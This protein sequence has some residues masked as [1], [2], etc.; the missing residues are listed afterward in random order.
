MIG[1]RFGMFIIIKDSGKRSN[2]RGMIWRCRC[3][4]GEIKD[5]SYKLLKNELKPR[6]CGCSR[7]IASDKIFLSNIEKTETCWIWTGCSNK[8]G[9]GKIGTKEIASRRSYKYFVGDIPKGKQVCHIC[10]NRICVNPDHLFLGSIGDNMRDRTSKNRQA[11]G[12]CIASSVLNEDQVLSIRQQR[13]FGSKY[14]DLAEE[15]NVHWYAIRKICKNETWKHVALGQE[16]KN[17]VSPHDYNKKQHKTLIER[18]N[19]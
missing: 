15:F 10:D 4:C 11:K 5:V 9:Y 17:Y 2:D 3:D 1:Q 12:S 14:K 7:K 19:K 8:G 13:L 18:S 16:C 6:S